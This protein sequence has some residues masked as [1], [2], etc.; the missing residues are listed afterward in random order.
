MI[1]VILDNTVIGI[2]AMIL[3]VG[4]VAIYANR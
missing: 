4:L 2:V 1:Q 3:T